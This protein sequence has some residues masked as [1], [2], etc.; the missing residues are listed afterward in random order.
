[1]TMPA[2]VF[3]QG[4]AAAAVERQD[5]FQRPF[6]GVLQAEGPPAGLFQQF[7]PRVRRRGAFCIPAQRPVRQHGAASGEPVAQKGCKRVGFAPQESGRLI[8]GRVDALPAGPQHLQLPDNGGVA[9]RCRSRAHHRAFSGLKEAA[10]K[11]LQPGSRAVVRQPPRRGNIRPQGRID[12]I[13]AGKARGRAERRALA[14]GCRP[15]RL[16]QHRGSFM[17]RLAGGQQPR[18]AVAQI[19]EGAQS[20]LH[21]QHV[22][23][24]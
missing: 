20:R 13:P 19:D 7:D 24:P 5:G 8:P 2:R 17:R 9:G 4:Y 18:R 15:G 1:M 6:D 23:P 3:L 14:P 12:Q 21:A 10:C 22:A 16:H 11:A